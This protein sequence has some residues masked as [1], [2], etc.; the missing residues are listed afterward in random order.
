MFDLT[1]HQVPAILQLSLL[2]G[3]ILISPNSG[4]FLPNPDR[5]EKIKQ[6]V[7]P[8]GGLL[9]R[10]KT[11][12]VVLLFINIQDTIPSLPHKMCLGLDICR[13][14]SGWIWNRVLE[15]GS[16]NS[17]LLGS[18]ETKPDSLCHGSAHT[19]FSPS[20]FDFVEVVPSTSD[21]LIKTNRNAIL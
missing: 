5:R 12:P 9:L 1:R 2:Q 3:M 18:S 20:C 14:R 21:N 13:T 4:S 17:S 16:R 7:G 8:Q 6:W 11:L 19:L 10:G 15:G